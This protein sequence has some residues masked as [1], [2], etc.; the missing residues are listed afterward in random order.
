[1]LLHLYLFS[2]LLQ[3]VQ[4]PLPLTP[5]HLWLVGLVQQ[6]SFPS[7]AIYLLCLVLPLPLLALHL[8]FV[9]LTPP[10]LQTSIEVALFPLQ[11][12]LLDFFALHK[13]YVNTRILRQSKPLSLEYYFLSFYHTISIE[14]Q[15]HL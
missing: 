4:G 5:G 9:D 6:S 13:K 3:V 11:L 14:T 8:L 7:L 2:L 10:F 1:M 15:T 12:P